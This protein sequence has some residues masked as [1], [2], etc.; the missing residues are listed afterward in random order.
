M[1]FEGAKLEHCHRSA[2]PGVL[3]QEQV[4]RHKRRF[5]LE[6]RARSKDKSACAT[7]FHPF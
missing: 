5:A 6:V 1:E 3:A 2:L 7:L 4:L